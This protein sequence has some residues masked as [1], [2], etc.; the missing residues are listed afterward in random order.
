MSKTK[1]ED[2]PPDDLVTYSINEMH[3]DFNQTTSA[4]PKISTISVQS[5]SQKDD[6]IPSITKLAINTLASTGPTE[7]S[8]K[9]S[10]ARSKTSSMKSK[11]KLGSKTN[12]VGKLMQKLKIEVADMLPMRQ[13]LD[14]TLYTQRLGRN[15]PPLMI[16]EAVKKLKST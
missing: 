15:K 4:V 10:R 14:A 13:S 2:G 6:K 1:I 16:K 3:G 5:S 9:K 12:S 8:E 11:S 7:I